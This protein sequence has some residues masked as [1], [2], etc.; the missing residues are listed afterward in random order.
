VTDHL[1]A[2]RLR[3][4]FDVRSGEFHAKSELDAGDI[5]LIS[6]GDL[7]NGLVGYFDISEEV[8]HSHALTVAYNGSWPIMTKFHPYE[9]GAKD[10]V[11]VLIPLQPMRD[12]LMLYIASL[13]NGMIWRY[14]YGRKCFRTKL[15]N[16]SLL[17]PVT[18]AD[19]KE[20][21]DERVPIEL[22]NKAII[23]VTGG[24]QQSIKRL[25]G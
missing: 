3:E 8:R 14:S 10:D 15:Q 20:I 22:F 24:T 21:I 25:F 5:P 2:F 23:R 4:L 12:S 19:G 11:A 18:L 9:F 17:L 13:L 16:V 1:K 6:C 7:H